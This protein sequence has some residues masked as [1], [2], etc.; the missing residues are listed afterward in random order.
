MKKS[1][2]LLM[3]FCLIT[4][5]AGA[6]YDSKL[7]EFRSSTVGSDVYAI[8]K[9]SRKG[10]RIKV[11]YFASKSSDGTTVL[12]RYN[13]WARNRNVVAVAAGTYMTTCTASNSLPVGICIDAGNVI[14]EE[15][16]NRLDGLAI[17]YAT[18]GMATSNLRDGNLKIVSTSDN[19]ERILDLKIPYDKSQFMTWARAESATVFQTHLFVYKNQIK[20][21]DNSS[22]QVAP[23][24]FLA[25][26]R[27]D[28]GELYHYLIN[29]PGMSTILDGS[30]KAFTYLQKQEELQEVIFLI[31]LDT[32]CQ[33]ILETYTPDGK[34][35]PSKNFNGTV[36]FTNAINLVVYY[37]E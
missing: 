8:V 14:N 26:C 33:N 15:N 3:L 1:N 9:M 21:G 13:S 17:V 37:Y 16:T 5:F 28:D 18:G 12:Q 7:V 19:K 23:R 25:V 31:N 36:S 20:V 35:N 34:V 2:C 29:L 32:G 22:P 30:K 6:Q 27:G 10:Q 24:R 11:K 4:F